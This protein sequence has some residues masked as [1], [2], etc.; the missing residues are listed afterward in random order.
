M[1][2]FRLEAPRRGGV[3][4]REWRRRVRHTIRLLVLLPG[5]AA[6]GL[7]ILGRSNTS[8]GKLTTRAEVDR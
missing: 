2:I 3:R 1:W 5:S 8:I 6:T 7:V 4:I